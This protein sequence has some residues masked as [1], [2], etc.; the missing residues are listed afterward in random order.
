MTV[1]RKAKRAARQLL[2]LCLV[3]GVLNDDR[4]RL[5]AQRLASSR[6]RGS[7]AVLSAFHRLVRLDRDRHTALVESATPLG[8]DLRDRIRRDLV[9]KYGRGLHADFVDA[10]A[11]IGG[12]RIRIGSDVFD[13]SVRARLN[14]LEARL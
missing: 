8:A 3:D 2:R 9:R 12:M 10:P 5:V 11:L 1:K 7:L 13:T 6:Q 14:S 4:V